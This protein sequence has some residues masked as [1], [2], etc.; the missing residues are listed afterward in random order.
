MF[1]PAYSQTLYTFLYKCHIHNGRRVFT[2]LLVLC[3]YLSVA[4]GNLNLLTSIVSFEVIECI[5]CN[6]I[7][8]HVWSGLTEFSPY[9]QVNNNR[10]ESV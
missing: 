4:Y 3:T 8:P 7:L 6:P 9:K 2:T 1:L 5:S 10:G